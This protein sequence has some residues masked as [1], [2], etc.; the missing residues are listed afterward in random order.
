VEWIRNGRPTMVG[1]SS[2]AV[3]GLVAITPS[4][5]FVS[6]L[7]AVGL[8]L[9]AG[10]VCAL[11]VGLKFRFGVDD[12]LDVFG[13]HGTGGTLGALMTGL[14]AQKAI[15]AAGAD[16]LFFGNASLF[17]AQAVAVLATWAYAAAVTYGLLKVLDVT[18]GLRVNAEQEDEGLDVAEHGESAYALD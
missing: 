8:G 7:G 18:M 2:G 5:A 3:A 4:C 16:G 10:A 1:A 12:S 9:V 13:V 11:A 6:P 15:N 14:F 17:G